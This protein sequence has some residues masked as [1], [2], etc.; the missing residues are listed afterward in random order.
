MSVIVEFGSDRPRLAPAPVLRNPREFIRKNL[1]TGVFE[2]TGESFSSG[3]YRILQEL[4]IVHS[5]ARILVVR[6][7]QVSMFDGVR[8]LLTQSYSYSRERWKL[9]DLDDATKV[10]IPR[11][12]IY[13]SITRL[14]INSDGNAPASISLTT[15]EYR[16]R[17]FK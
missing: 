17:Q 14:R 11:V 15:P 9:P 16:Y 13:G 7:E 4:D 8:G 12:R 2:P 3:L 6:P 10:E 5:T 1:D